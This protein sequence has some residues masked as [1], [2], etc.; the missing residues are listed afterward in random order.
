MIKF[1]SKVVTNSEVVVTPGKPLDL[2]CEGDGF[3]NWQTRLSKHRHFVSKGNGNARTLRVERPSAE[4][5]GTYK[6]FYSTRPQYR[7]LATSV[8]VY[9][10][11]RQ[12]FI[13]FIVK[14]TQLRDL[15]IS[16]LISPFRP[17]PFVL[18]QQHVSAGG[19]ERG[20]E[21]PS[22]LS[23]HQPSSH[24][25]WPPHGQWY[26]RTIGDE[27]YSRPS[28]WHS[29]PQPPPELQRR[30]RLHSQGEWGRKD[31]QGLLHQCYSE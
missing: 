6:C 31:L 13:C 10:Q 28:P 27:L 3:V 19:Q 15:D 1:N 29:Y 17:E 4:F 16:L 7:H 14:T 5:T 2:R 9:V 8:H 30:L 23:A 22:T 11:G 20:G 26:Q 12:D 21:L 24:R 25:P 18:D